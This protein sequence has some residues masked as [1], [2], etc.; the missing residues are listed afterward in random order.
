[1]TDCSAWC[2]S[3]SLLAK[4]RLLLLENAKQ[5]DCSG[6]SHLVSKIA[7]DWD[8]SEGQSQCFIATH[9]QGCSSSTILDTV[10]SKSGWSAQ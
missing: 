10:I 3:E 8:K 2:W 9:W 6:A 1:M 4:G 5:V 7:D